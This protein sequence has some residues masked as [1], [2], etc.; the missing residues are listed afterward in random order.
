MSSW[1]RLPSRA[2]LLRHA[3]SS[4]TTALFLLLFPL[5]PNADDA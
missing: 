1:F 2:R 3:L 5:T 4:M